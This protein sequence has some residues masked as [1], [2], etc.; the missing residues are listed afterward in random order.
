MIGNKY[1][2]H[3]QAEIVQWAY[4]RNLIEG[5]TREK[6]L[7]KLMEELGELAAGLVRNDKE[8]IKDSIG[9]AAV[10]LIILNEMSGCVIHK[11][12]EVIYRGYDYTTLLVCTVDDAISYNCQLHDIN[13]IA[14]YNNLTLEECIEAAWQEIKDRKGRMI[15]GVFVKEA[16][17][18]NV[19][20]NE[21]TEQ[22]ERPLGCR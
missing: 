11:V 13:H 19:G 18:C 12:E 16:D 15:D 5:S 2:V 3:R 20:K 14:V 1:N 17:L 7:L 9:D 6:Q 4:D 8:K 22:A 21:P 10:V